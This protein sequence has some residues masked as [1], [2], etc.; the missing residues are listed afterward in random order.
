MVARQTALHL[1]DDIWGS[2]PFQV[3]LDCAKSHI[4]AT[5]EQ[6]VLEIG[7]GVGRCI[8][9]IAKHFPES[10]CW[11]VDYSYQMLKQAARYWL[12]KKDINI[13]LSTKG[14]PSSL[15]IKGYSLPNLQ[16][17]LSKANHL[18]FEGNS[19]DLVFNSFLIDR[20]ENPQNGLIEMYRILK[21]G[22]KLSVISPLNFSRSTH[23]ASYYPPVKIKSLLHQ[24]GF[25]LLDW[26]EDILINEPLDV[27]GNV[28]QWKC[29]G[30]VA[31]K[32]R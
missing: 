11:G 21:K 6:S 25:H 3:V 22:G 4:I 9:S 24:I 32:T 7:C 31:Q 27:H 2:Y 30:F 15:L 8:G 19:Q 26:Q 12:D 16:F 23:W 20:L 13:D 17:G 1:A 18:P 14:F 29:I 28:V 10:N 5:Q